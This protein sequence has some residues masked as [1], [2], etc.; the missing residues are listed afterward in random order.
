MC[1]CEFLLWHRGL[2][3]QHCHC[4][5]L[6]HCRDTVW[7]LAWKF[8]HAMG[9]AKKKKKERKKERKKCVFVHEF[10]HFPMQ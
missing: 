6:G 9:A 1:L 2:R 8:P 4:G 10:P 5:G 7:S 3:I